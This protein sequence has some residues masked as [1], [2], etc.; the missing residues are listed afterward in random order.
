MRTL[1]VQAEEEF[2]M[3]RFAILGYQLGHTLS[4]KLHRLLVEAGAMPERAE[5]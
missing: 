3:K 5:D 4:Q 1:Q 2:V